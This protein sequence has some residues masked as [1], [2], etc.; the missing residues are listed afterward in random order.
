MAL[1]EVELE[2]LRAAGLHD[3]ATALECKFLSL[4]KVVRYGGYIGLIR[5]I[6]MRRGLER[7]QTAVNLTEICALGF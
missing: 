4:S 6:A 3:I 5:S 1:N 2:W 7:G